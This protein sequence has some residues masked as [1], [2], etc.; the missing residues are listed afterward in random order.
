MLAKCMIIF[1]GMGAGLKNVSW[2]EIH[3]LGSW[4]EEADINCTS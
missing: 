1:P 2:L 4:E 3:G